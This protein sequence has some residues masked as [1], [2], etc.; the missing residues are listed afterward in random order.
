MT[1]QTVQPTPAPTLAEQNRA[2]RKADFL[3]ALQTYGT[4]SATCLRTG[5]ARRTVYDWR[6][7]DPTFNAACETW[8]THDMEAELVDSIYQIATSNDP[9][10]ANAAVKAGEF[11]LK[12]LNRERYGDQLKTES[13][14]NINVQISTTTE[15]RDQFRAQQLKKLTALTLDMETT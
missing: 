11:L 6:E 10:T 9:K 2:K 5:T 15:V 4:L 12:S 14:Q 13:T 3:E 7:Q 8:L 1:A